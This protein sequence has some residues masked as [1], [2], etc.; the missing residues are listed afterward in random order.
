MGTVCLSEAVQ[1]RATLGDNMP[2]AI[3][4]RRFLSLL[5]LGGSA[6]LLGACQ[7]STPGAPTPAA[8]KPSTAAAPA[9]ASP[10]AQAAPSPAASA[11]LSALAAPSP[12]P[13]AAPA[14]AA[15]SNAHIRID[16]QSDVTTLNPL[17]ANAA[18]TRR[19]AV[20][21]FAALYQY[22]DKNN[23]VA[24][25]ADGMP[26]MPD[27]Q[28]YLVK[29]KSNAKFHSGR[30]L[31]A[32]DVKFTYDQV[33]DTQYGSIWRS[34]IE[35]AVD[36]VTARDAT[37][38][39]VKLKRP[40]LPMLTKMAM[41]P[42]V[43]AQQSKD[44]LAQK[45]DGAGPF[46]MVSYQKGS[47][48]E[49]ARHDGYH[50]PGQPRIGTTSIYVVPEEASR[51]TNL[52]NGTSHLAPEPA[53][54]GLDVLKGRGLSI[55]SVAS[56]AGT[57]GFI[58]F[59]RAD[60]PLTNKD[61]RRA[62]AY[63]MD[64]SAVVANVWGG[65]GTPGQT[66]IRPQT[67]AYDASFKP[68]PDQSDPANAKEAAQASGRG[69]DR[70]VITTANDDTLVATATVIQSAARAA[71]LNVDVAQIDRAA[72]LS[73]L[74]KDD[75]DVII[76]DSYT[77]SNSGFEPDYVLALDASGASANFGK[78]S[79]PEMDNEVQAAVFATSRDAARPHYERIMQIEA[80]DVPFLVVVYHN[81][82]EA[83]SP[84]LSG[85]QTSGLAQY[86]LRTLQLG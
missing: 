35:P 61:L 77:S 64:R 83:V 5:G 33:L 68:W 13:Q 74:Q 29:L 7:S 27:P 78:Y 59:K 63:A 18:P 12:S 67:W 11:S 10:A 41:I 62:L 36:T 45:P 40:Y 56:P 28:T 8:A 3:P 48:L 86:D 17:L 46:K 23:L 51:V 9:A 15:A 44:D 82:V 70:I 55:N 52:A 6:T 2:Q 73:A 69:G 24:D 66:M 4:R 1:A 81:Y 39:E 50:F 54:S 76:T 80:D 21:I 22:D 31:T 42:I 53:I 16:E 57:Y 20:Q 84:K 38:I 32:E 43:N 72:F 60:A 26:Q 14:Q 34:H 49:L 65:Q 79:N 25:L 30:A 47:V 19:R 37:T 85:Y 71:G 75:W 58:N